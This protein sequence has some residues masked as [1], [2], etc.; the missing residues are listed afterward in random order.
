MSRTGA[1]EDEVAELALALVETFLP[2]D[3]CVATLR[4]AGDPHRLEGAEHTVRGWRE[5]DVDGRSDRRITDAQ[6]LLGAASQST[7]H[8]VVVH[9]REGFLAASVGGFVLDGLDQD[10]T[11]FVIVTDEHRDAVAAWLAGEG[12]DVAT[13]RSSGRYVEFDA[14]A[15]LQRL[16]RP[17]G[18]LDAE[19]F[20]LEVGTQVRAATRNGQ[21]VRAYGEM[22]ALLWD[23]GEFDLALEL[24][25]RWNDTLTRLP[26]PLLCGYPLD[27][28]ASDGAGSRFHEMC[29]RHSSVATDSY[30]HVDDAAPAPFGLVTLDTTRPGG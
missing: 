21:G 14:R 18:T 27:A 29:G 5:R 25:D 19:A 26:I 10:E 22:V 16:R 1:A 2:L 15:T 17:S 13:S 6:R 9:E 28:F 3:E 4:Q 23:E 8:V 30:A 11:V 20:L 12:H 24:E 7:E